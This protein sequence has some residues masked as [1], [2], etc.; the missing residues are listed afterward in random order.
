[1]REGRGWQRSGESLSKVNKHARPKNLEIDRQGCWER[2]NKLDFNIFRQPQIQRFVC[3]KAD[4]TGQNTFTVKLHQ[5]Q[6]NLF[7]KWCCV[8]RL[9]IKRWSHL[10]SPTLNQAKLKEK[11]I[12]KNFKNPSKNRLGV[13]GQA[14]H[15]QKNSA[16]SL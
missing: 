4:N 14:T 11:R 2:K 7:N 1:M 9:Y 3:N 5:N 15:K 8:H 12:F 13:M 10:F 6:A 16:P